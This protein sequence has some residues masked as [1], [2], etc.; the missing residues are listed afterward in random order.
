MMMMMMM[1]M[2]C[3]SR[4]LNSLYLPESPFS[5]I[6]LRYFLTEEVGL[7]DGRGAPARVRVQSVILYLLIS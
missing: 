5:F 3:L 1:M 4:N 2:N 6:I 7:Q